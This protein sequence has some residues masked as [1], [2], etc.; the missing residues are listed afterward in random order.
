LESATLAGER[1]T[2]PL[3]SEVRDVLSDRIRPVAQLWAV[4]YAADW[5][6]TAPGLL[7]S[8]LPDEW[9]R[10]LISIRT[11]GIWADVD[12]KSVTLNAAA[13]CDNAKTAEQLLNWLAKR[14]NSKNPPTLARDD[15]WLSI[16]SKTDLDSFRGMLAP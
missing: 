4:G 6:K 7:L 12:A 11:F 9:Q 13:R 8:R 16:Q 10:R 5:S 3:V 15:N 1:K 2:D 14:G